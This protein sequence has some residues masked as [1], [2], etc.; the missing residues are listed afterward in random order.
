MGFGVF[1]IV[2]DLHSYLEIKAH[3]DLGVDDSRC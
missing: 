1:F 2:L 3:L